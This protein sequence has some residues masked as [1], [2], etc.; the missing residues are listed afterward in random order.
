M[1]VEATHTLELPR[2]APESRQTRIGVRG[3]DTQANQVTGPGV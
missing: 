2:V 1:E 3:T